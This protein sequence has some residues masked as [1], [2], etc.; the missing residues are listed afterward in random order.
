MRGKEYLVAVMAENG[1]LSAQTLRFADELRSPKDVG[2]PE[3]KKVDKAAVT[4][5]EKLITKYAK[6]GLAEGELKDQQTERLLKLVK[7]KKSRKKDVVETEEEQ[8]DRSNVVDIME[9]LKKSMA[10]KKRA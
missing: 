1:I 10:A 5:F 4:K 9:V 2:L 3:E 6:S 8:G 7:S